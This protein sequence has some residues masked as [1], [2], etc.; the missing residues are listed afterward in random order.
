M[1]FKKCPKCG[2]LIKHSTHFHRHVKRCGTTEH[3]V[4]CPF[5]PKTFTRKDNL[6]THIKKKHT[7]GANAKEHR[8]EN[9]QKTFS[10]EMAFDLHQE[11]CGKEK[12]KPFKCTFANCGKCFS[13]KSTLEHHQQHTHLSQLGGDIKRKV[14]EEESKTNVKKSKI[15]KETLKRKLEEKESERKDKKIRER[16]RSEKVNGVSPADRE[17]S[18]MKGAKVDAFFYPKTESETMDQQVFFKDTLPRLKKHLQKE[19]KEKKAIKW[20][21]MYHCTLEMPD[22][23]RT[24]PLKYEGYF[25]T[26]NPLIS[27]YPQQLREQLNMAMEAVEERMA[28]FMQ[29]GSGWTLSRNHALGVRNSELS[30]LRR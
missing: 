1:A 20:N 16:E 14:E 15:P 21:L 30:T 10:Y 4:S 22:K 24:E 29:A 18:S 28:T 13:R 2:V 9:C 17:V 27:T 19:R 11:H 26:P 5:C 6:K 7:E 8:C 25:R 23:Y 12:A 3:Q